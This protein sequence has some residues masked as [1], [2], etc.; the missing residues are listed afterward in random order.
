[1]TE[2]DKTTQPP[3]LPDGVQVDGQSSPGVGRVEQTVLDDP[4][5]QSQPDTAP[6]G[7]RQETAETSPFSEALERVGELLRQFN[8]F[9][10]LRSKL[11]QMAT[12]QL[13]ER[14]T[15]VNELLV[16]V[17]R[18][19]PASGSDYQAIIHQ[20]DE[21]LRFARAVEVDEDKKQSAEVLIEQLTSMDHLLKF[22]AADGAVRQLIEY[23]TL[24]QSEAG[25]AVDSLVRLCLHFNRDLQ[26]IGD[27][28]ARLQ[29]T[30]ASTA[31]AVET[32]IALINAFLLSFKE[33]LKIARQSNSE[34][35]LTEAQVDEAFAALRK[36]TL[37]A[38]ASKFYRMID[39]LFAAR[40]SLFS[41]LELTR[42]TDPN[43][44]PSMAKSLA[45][46]Q[47]NPGSAAE[48]INKLKIFIGK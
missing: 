34:L 5:R 46:A 43:S 26:M 19:P 13:Q 23:V 27:Q 25:R 15:A 10:L 37:T 17:R 41:H 6:I 18:I 4:A 12:E 2:I 1:M 33:R 40:D 24:D 44:L 9:S 30:D 32:R 20:L 36:S 3:S 47:P 16:M 11:A 8:E 42:Q 21:Q 31:E 7:R 38:D 14:G 35:S 28:I 39:V 29:E 48:A 45:A 22:I